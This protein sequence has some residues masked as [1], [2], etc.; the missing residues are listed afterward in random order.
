VPL[1]GPSRVFLLSPRAEKPASGDGLTGR[2]GFLVL[3][4]GSFGAA[5][6]RMGDGRQLSELRSAPH[7]HQR[8]AL[9]AVDRAETLVRDLCHGSAS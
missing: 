5:I 1:F 4:L 3:L 6:P 8:N 9:S 7:R 2:P